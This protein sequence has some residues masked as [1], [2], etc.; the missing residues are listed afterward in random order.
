MNKINIP[1]D[2]IEY[3]QYKLEKKGKLNRCIFFLLSN[4]FEIHR[5]SCYFFNNL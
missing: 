2:T 5:D 3:E 1:Y 4:I